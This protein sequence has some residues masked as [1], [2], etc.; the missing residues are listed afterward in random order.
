MTI[1]HLASRRADALDIRTLLMELGSFE[2]MLPKGRW[3][4]EDEGANF[5]LRN[6][7][8]ESFEGLAMLTVPSAAFNRYGRTLR[9]YTQALMNNFGRVEHELMEMSKAFQE[10]RNRAIALTAENQHLRAKLASLEP[11][12]ELENT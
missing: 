4:W 7:K 11:Q 8:S 6:A 10:Q 5:V 1:S 9:R 12:T 3:T 2:E